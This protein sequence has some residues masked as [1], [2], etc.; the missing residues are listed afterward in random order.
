MVNWT[1][2]CDLLAKI[3]PENQK[4]EKRK[5]RSKARSLGNEEMKSQ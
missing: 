3:R 2:K 4:R 1:G 5:G